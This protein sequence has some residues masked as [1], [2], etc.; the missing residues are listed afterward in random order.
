MVGLPDKFEIRGDFDSSSS[1]LSA[2]TT[3]STATICTPTFFTLRSS[4][5]TSTAVPQATS[6]RFP[7]LFDLSIDGTV[8]KPSNP[9]AEQQDKLERR[10][11]GTVWIERGMDYRGY[12]VWELAIEVLR[13]STLA[14]FL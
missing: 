1:G 10:G 11:F 5:P 6:S 8:F 9:L 7:H 12:R 14:W 4:T 3:G 13:P 2:S